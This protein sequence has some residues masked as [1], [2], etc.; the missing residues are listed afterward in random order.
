MK[1]IAIIPARYGSSRFEGKPLA[2]IFGKPMVVR[3]YQRVL[4]I[5]DYV[6]IATDN[7]IIKNKAEEFGCRVVMTSTEHN[8]GTDRCCEAL[9][10]V[11]N[12]L[13]TT[14]D[15][16]VNIQGDEPFIHSE[17]VE[18]VASAFSDINVDIATLVKPFTLN[19]DIFN[20]NTPKVVLSNEGK[21]LYFSRSVIPF[22]RGVEESE[23]QNKHT[24]YKHIGI[25][26]YRTN[27]L[28]EITQLSQSSL[29]LCESLEQLRWLEN[30]YYI[31][32]EITH[33][34]S[35]AVDTPE[36]LQNI[37]ELYADDKEL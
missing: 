5:F 31:K 4:S 9:K 36:D 20:P 30:G 8:T 24:F 21:A 18:L 1:F 35:H 28:K 16:V 3:V 14:F 25:Y 7:D 2:D 33:Q 29:E 27:V 12:E 15:V 17:Q 34:E 37:L 13:N 23:W 32:C 11:E 19:E 26:A 10:I 6:V 22:L